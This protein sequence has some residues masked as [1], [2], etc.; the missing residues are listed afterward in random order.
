[1][2]LWTHDSTTL[3][4]SAAGSTSHHASIIVC[5]SP[6]VCIAVAV[7]SPAGPDG[8]SACPAAIGEVKPP[9]VCTCTSCGLHLQVVCT[10]PRRV[11]AV[12]IAQ[13]VA[14]EMGVQLGSTV[15]YGVRFE[16]AANQVGRPGLQI[17]LVCGVAS[18]YYFCI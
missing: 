18:C 14:E 13:R 6:V 16:N 11:A 2:Q 7:D 9:A 8:L 4:P 17:V 5:W 15:G 12:T 1:M 3:S 10:Q